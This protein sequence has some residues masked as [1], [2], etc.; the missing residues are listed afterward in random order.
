MS[1]PSGTYSGSPAPRI[2]FVWSNTNWCW[3]FGIPIMSQMMRIGNGAESSVTKSHSPFSTTASMASR[4]AR[5]TFSSRRARR[6]RVNSGDTSLRCRMC[7]GSSMLMKLP[8]NSRNMTG[9]SGMLVAPFD[10]Q[11]SCGSRLARRMSACFVTAQ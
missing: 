8:K 4:A 3:L 9:M 10:E 7:F 11:K 6:W 1:V 2:T 5:S